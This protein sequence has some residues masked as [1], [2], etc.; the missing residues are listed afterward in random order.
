MITRPTITCTT[1]S[2]ST[3]TSMSTSMSISPI[4]AD[5]IVKMVRQ[6]IKEQ[7]K[8]AKENGKYYEPWDEGIEGVGW[9]MNEVG[10]FNDLYTI[11][12]DPKFESDYSDVET[13]NEFEKLLSTCPPYYLVLLQKFILMGGTSIDGI[14]EIRD[15]KSASEIMKMFELDLTREWNRL[16]GTT[17]SISSSSN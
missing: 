16:T 14:F 9:L 8:E 10:F 13:V 1:M 5:Y 7:E 17:D 6:T 12:V 2:A 4:L 11:A 3:S 15:R